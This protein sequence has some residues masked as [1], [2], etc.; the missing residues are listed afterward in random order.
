MGAAAQAVRSAQD[1]AE[2]AIT[3]ISNIM[4]YEA[5]NLK[6]EWGG[7][8]AE[9]PKQFA[10]SYAQNAANP[11]IDMNTRLAEAEALAAGIASNIAAAGGA[12]ATVD[13]KVAGATETAGERIA[14]EEA[15]ARENSGK[16]GVGGSGGAGRGKGSGGAMTFNERVAEM[17]GNARAQRDEELAA[18]Y[19]AGGFMRSAVRAQDRAQRRRDE[20]MDRGRMKDH[21]S[22]MGF[23]NMGEAFQQYERDVPMSERMTEQEFKDFQKQLTEQAKTPQERSAEEEA[24]REKHGNKGGEGTDFVSKIYDLIKTHIPNIDEKLPQT[25]LVYS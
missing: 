17:Q 11:L 22:A 13:P 14:R 20:A 6:S 10:D 18:R 21:L 1:E 16:S 24:M 23:N 15:E 8:M 3:D 2:Q 25:A 4:H 9:M 5:D 19:E 12:A 7:I